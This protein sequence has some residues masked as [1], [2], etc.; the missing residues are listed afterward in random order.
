ML[1]VY[2]YVYTIV[3]YHITWGGRP[4][5][6]ALLQT[7]QNLHLIHITHLCGVASVSGRISVNNM[8][9]AW[10]IIW[11]IQQYNN[12]CNDT[13]STSAYR[14]YTTQLIRYSR[15]YGYY[16]DF[17]DRGLLLSRKLLNQG[18]L[19]VKLKS[20]LPNFCGCHHDLAMRYE[21]SVIP[22]ICSTCRKC[23]HSTL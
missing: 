2:I 4:W 19:L 22:R 5:L 9:A 23:L 3:I 6:Y 21:I 18:V 15:A 14:V 13:Y 11:R 8:V 20:S 16:Q 17:P 7:F 1:L 12:S 10:C